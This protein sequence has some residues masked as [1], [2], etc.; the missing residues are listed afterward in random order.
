MKYNREIV[1]GRAFTRLGE[2]QYN[3]ASNN[4]EHYVCWCR[5]GD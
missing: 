3:L 2:N 4:C 5:N 1:I